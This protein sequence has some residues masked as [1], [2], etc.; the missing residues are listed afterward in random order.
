[1]P[2]LTTTSAYPFARSTLRLLLK[3]FAPEAAARG[4]IRT[5]PVL[6]QRSAYGTQQTSIAWLSMSA[7]MLRADMPSSLADVRW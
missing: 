4:H 6:L 1:M 3:A 7:P 5:V 2:L